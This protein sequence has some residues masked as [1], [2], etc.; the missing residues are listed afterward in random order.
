MKKLLANRLYLTLWVSDIISNFGDTVYYLALMNYALFLPNPK[1]AIS[2]ITL[3]ETIPY[4]GTFLTG[5]LGDKT[6]EKIKT[7][8]LTLLVRVLFYGLVALVMG[9]SPAMWILLFVCIVNFLSDFAGQYE[10][11]LFYPISNRLIDPQD[12]EEVMA[13]RQS[14]ST[15]LTVVF[16]ATG[17]ILIT[18]LT[19]R[20]LAL[21]NMASF[22]LA[23]LI[24]KSVNKPLSQLLDKGGEVEQEV[25]A[26]SLKDMRKELGEAYGIL[27]KVDKVKDTLF[28]VPFINAGL[29]I[30]VPLVILQLTRSSQM[31]LGSEAWVI[32]LLSMSLTLGTISGGIA[33]LLWVK[34]LTIEQL[35]Y[36]ELATLVGL[37]ASLY[38]Q[39]IY[40]VLIFLFLANTWVGCLNPKMGALIFQ[41]IPEEKLGTAWGGIA[42]YFQL[43]ELIARGLLAIAV[44]FLAPQTIAIGFI[45]MLLL[46]VAIE[47]VKKFFFL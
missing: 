1:L 46:M 7:I 37:F 20:Q 17:A 9:F 19:Y 36:L 24:F 2:L 16:Q 31:I 39:N 11:S 15:S 12:R 8:E 23:L 33:T 30:I 47:E 13:F 14:I 10:N 45:I 34:K 27:T 25:S 28:I 35:L 5:Y 40:A 38:W 4:L 44:L 6:A 42:T 26:I 29:V 41:S 3:S 22:L 32:S 21:I 18:W 43:G